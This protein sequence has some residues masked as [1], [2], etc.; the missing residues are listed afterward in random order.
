LACACAR[1]VL[2]LAPDSSAFTDAIEVAERY[3]DGVATD[4]DFR[5]ARRAVKKAYLVL[6][7][8]MSESSR[9]AAHAAQS[10][11]EKEFFRYKMSIE[12]AQAAE[13]AR[14]RP[15][16]DAGQ[17]QEALAQC[18]LV[19]DIFGP[20]PFRPLPSLEGSVRA[21]ND[22]F[23]LKLA[24]AIYEERSLPEGRLDPQGLAVLG[25]ALEEAGCTDP[26]ILGHLRQQGAVHV[27]GCFVVDLV[28]DRK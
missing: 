3:A 6:L 23:I 18:A 5:A 28:L 24:T 12:N 7:G 14:R 25:D 19:R 16:W 20:L 10:T 26:D 15:E 11:L 9:F 13:A 17:Q 1:R 2:P 8:S 21:W 4:A 27:R 22:G